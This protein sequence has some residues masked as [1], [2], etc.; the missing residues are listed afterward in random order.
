[1]MIGHVQNIERMNKI[2]YLQIFYFIFMITMYV[3]VLRCEDGKYYVGKTNNPDI[4]LDRHFSLTGSVW[5][6]R[7]KPLEVVQIIPNCD[8]LDEDK[9]VKKM[10]LK[11]GIN[12]MRGG[13]YSTSVLTLNQKQILATELLSAQDKCYRC[14][15]VGHFVKECPNKWNNILLKDRPK[16]KLRQ[17]KLCIE[18]ENSKS[19]KQCKEEIL[20]LKEE[21][22]QLEQNIA[23][24]SESNKSRK[25]IETST[26]DIN[27]NI[28]VESVDNNNL[29]EE[30]KDTK[31]KYIDNVGVKHVIDDDKVKPVI[32]DNKVKRNLKDAI[33]EDRVMLNND[34]KIPIHN[35]NDDI[36]S[37]RINLNPY[38]VLYQTIHIHSNDN[39]YQYD[40]T[41]KRKRNIV[42]DD[43]NSFGQELK[44]RY[45][46]RD[47][48]TKDDKEG[49]TYSSSYYRV[50]RNPNYRKYKVYR[51]KRYVRRNY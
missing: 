32:D 34:I 29:I 43:N 19:K 15:E 28:K 27:N 26:S 23:K 49:N 51:R 46:Q 33:F 35:L 48:F 50:R 20:K 4:R 9:W 1:M 2:K 44:M 37:N 21:I 22:N 24:I 7:Y 5:T 14:G 47:C 38:F 31:N 30:I 3:Y 42:V 40:S 17:T 8:A 36:N 45:S 39:N 6:K 41:H 18:R 11:Y 16:K 25:N 13:S 12:N 10:I